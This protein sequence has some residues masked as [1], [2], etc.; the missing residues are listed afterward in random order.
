MYIQVGM[1]TTPRLRSWLNRLGVKTLFIETGTPRE[2]G[3]IESFNGKFRDELLNG[4]IFDTILEARAITERWRR[5]FNTERPH[6]SLNHRQ[7]APVDGSTRRE[8][9]LLTQATQSD[10]NEA[11]TNI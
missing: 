3:Y 7:L 5:H 4:E 10:L 2:N 8:A 11:I 6:S 9:I 1:L